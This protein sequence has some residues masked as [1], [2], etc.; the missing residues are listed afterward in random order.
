MR[1]RA[2]AT[3]VGTVLVGLAL[4][5]GSACEK[6]KSSRTVSLDAEAPHVASAQSATPSPAAASGADMVRESCLPCHSEEILLQQRL[7]SDQWAAVVKKMRGWG[8]ALEPEREIALVRYLAEHYTPDA[9]AFTPQVIEA[10]DAAA[11]LAALPDGPFAGGD[12][13]HGATLFAQRCTA[14]HGA[15]AGGGVGVRL[16]DRV[17]IHRAPEFDRVV[18]EGRGRMPAASDLTPR[19]VAD[20]LAHLRALTHH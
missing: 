1:K 12:A 5:L 14:C 19:D 3:F 10:A 9:G 13:A 2:A 18:R 17:L 20:I 8:A 15:D 6:T 11:E 7:T 4:A 16:A